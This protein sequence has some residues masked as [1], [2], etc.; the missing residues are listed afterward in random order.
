MKTST[1]EKIK[2]SF[3]EVKGMIKEEGG[4]FTRT[5]T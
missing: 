3:P 5:A 2:G 4:K 1:K